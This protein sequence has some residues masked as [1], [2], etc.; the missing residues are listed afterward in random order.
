M[1]LQASQI[2]ACTENKVVC[3]PAGVECVASFTGKVEGRLQAVVA[4]FGNAD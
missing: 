1:L 2:D 4:T 3:V